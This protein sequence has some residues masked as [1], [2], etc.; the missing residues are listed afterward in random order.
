MKINQ[1]L[2]IYLN[3]FVL[4]YCFEVELNVYQKN[5]SIMN[6]T[7]MK[8]INNTNSKNELFNAEK[9]FLSKCQ[10][11]YNTEVFYISPDKNII[12]FTINTTESLSNNYKMPIKDP[13]LYVNSKK[14]QSE[15]TLSN[16]NDKIYNLQ[17]NTICKNPEN[18]NINRALQ[19]KTIKNYGIYKIETYSEENHPDYNDNDNFAVLNFTFNYNK[20]NYN[21]SFVKICFFDES[22]KNII[23]CC[24]IMFIAFIYVY[25]STYMKLDFK[26]VKEVQEVSSDIKW[27]HIIYSVI[28]GS[29]ILVSIYLFKK[30]IFII[31]NILIG[32]ESWLCTYYANLFFVLQI[33]K[34]FFSIIK[35]KELTHKKYR[36]LFDMTAY[37][38]ASAVI[39]GF[40]IMFYFITRHW[41]LNDIICFCLAFTTLSFIVLK[42]FMLCFIC[43]FSFFIYDTFWVFYSEKIFKEN[44]MVV[45][46]TSIQIPIKIEFPILFSNNPIKNCMLLG[47]GDILLPG[48]VIKYCRRFDLIRQKLQ[49]KIKEISFFNFN[50]ILYFISVALAMIMMFVF[51]HGQPVLFY[52]SPIFIVGL[53]GKAYKDECFNDFWNGL[54]L[55]K[56]KNINKNINNISEKDKKEDN[57]EESDDDDE[58]EEEEDED[59]NKRKKFMNKKIQQTELQMLNNNN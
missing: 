59:K 8:N 9:I 19:S 10:C 25:F 21:F 2:L 22:W 40:L 54:K 11:N 45:A 27:Y 28:F 57:E 5:G 16:I 32:L 26:F 38:I 53:M 20:T 6:Y 44:V 50:L 24:C 14:L 35:H 43:L 18:K 56:P 3:I 29:V 4:I 46:A 36:L 34:K 39:S 55:K 58:E 48:L 31:L 33:G 37:E 13:I 49:P 1:F 41:L 47:L 12:N 52:I 23:S 30:Y 51:N 42:S 7:I 15:Y 17:I